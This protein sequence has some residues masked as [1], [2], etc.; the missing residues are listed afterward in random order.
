MKIR[1]KVLLLYSQSVC[2]N[3]FFTGQSLS[4]LQNRQFQ[5]LQKVKKM[6]LQTPFDANTVDPSQSQ[7]QLPI[8][9]HKVIIE[10]SE[11]K[12]NNQGTGG[13]LQLNLKIVEGPNAGQTGADRLNLY[14]NN[15]DAVQIAKRHLSAYCHVTGVFVVQNSQQLHGIP[16]IVEVAP[17]KKEPSRTEVVRVYDING[18]EPG[19]ASAGQQ[20]T[21]Q[22]PAQ[23][24]PQVSAPSAP[25]AGQWAQPPAQAPVAQPEVA[26]AQGGWAP[27]APAQAPAGQQQ[28]PAQTGAMPP[29]GNP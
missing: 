6:Q 27:Q 10:S 19:K 13:Y 3:N 9:K 8:G 25:A 5:L 26:P 23:T 15:Q 7:G 12:E 16:F 29:W 17:Q 1:G 24:Q 2:D 28:A 21:A 20:P 14:H 4:Y 22:A 18:N 11:G